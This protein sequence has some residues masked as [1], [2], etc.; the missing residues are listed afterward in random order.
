MWFSYIAFWFALIEPIKSFFWIAPDTVAVSL[1]FLSG[2]FVMIFGLGLVR[3]TLAY[4]SKKLGSVGLVT[5]RIGTLLWLT[6]GMGAFLIFVD[7]KT[8]L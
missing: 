6:S 7:N 5:G 8:D 3:E 1:N 4:L 2:V